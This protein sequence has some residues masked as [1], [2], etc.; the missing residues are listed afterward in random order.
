MFN[1]LMVGLLLGMALGRF[2]RV[3]V[4]VPG[5]ALAIVLAMSGP[6]V[7]ASSIGE[8]LI[9][10]VAIV[11]ALQMGYVASLVFTHIQIALPRARRLTAPQI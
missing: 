10:I 8:T 11:V 3:Y 1:L 6:H 2:F 9:E 7:F 5:C 4:L